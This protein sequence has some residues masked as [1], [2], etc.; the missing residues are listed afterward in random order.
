M[1]EGVKENST[2]TEHKLL[3]V[4]PV[5]P[6]LHARHVLGTTASDVSVVIYLVTVLHYRQRWSL[7]LCRDVDRSM[8]TNERDIFKEPWTY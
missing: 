3:N 2:S 5:Y 1:G 6:S 8:G 4:E 7:C